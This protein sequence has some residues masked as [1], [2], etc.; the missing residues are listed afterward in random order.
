MACLIFGIIWLYAI[1][2]D[3]DCLWPMLPHFCHRMALCCVAQALLPLARVN[4]SLLSYMAVPVW[5][6]YHCLWAG[7]VHLCHRVA[8]LHMARVALPLARVNVSLSS[9]GCTPYGASIVAFGLGH[10]IFAIVWLKVF[11]PEHYCLWPGLPPLCNR[12][13]VL[14]MAQIFLPVAW[15]TSSSP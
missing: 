10:L 11:W 3:Y 6:E 9:Y 8:V 12:M 7:L 13:V 15:A 14:R 2:R 4:S 5:R 1:W